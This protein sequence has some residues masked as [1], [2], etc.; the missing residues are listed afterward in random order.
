MNA[1]KDKQRENKPK[2][3]LASGWITKYGKP[4]VV[5]EHPLEDI[6][7]FIDNG[8]D[9]VLRLRYGKLPAGEYQTPIE[10]LDALTEEAWRDQLE[11]LTTL[12]VWNEHREAWDYITHV[13]D[14]YSQD[15]VERHLES[16]E[17]SSV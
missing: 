13:C 7:A 10:A 9:E 3:R 4:V 14:F 6:Q 2:Y 11:I 16:L 8:H 17:V 1:T 5:A 12:E 15:D